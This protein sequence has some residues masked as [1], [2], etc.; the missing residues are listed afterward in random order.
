MSHKIIFMG[1]PQFSVPSLE[2]L[3]KSSYKISCVYTQPPKKSN[4]GHKLNSSLIQKSAEDLNLTVRSP[5]SLNTDEELKHFKDLNP[6]IVV[7]VAYGQL[8]PKKFLNV[9]K[10]GFIN[11]HASLLPRWRGAAPIQR[12]IINLDKETGVS[13]MKI[14][15]ELDSGPIMKKIKMKISPSDSSG[16]ILE[17]LS[18]I[19]SNNIV[20]ALDDIFEGREK[21]IEQDHNFV[22]YAKK[23]KKHEGKIDWKE[24]A[25]FIIGKINGLNP[26]PGAWFEYKKIRYKIWQASIIEKK[27]SVGTILDKSFT[28]A[29]NDQSIRIIEIQKEGKKKL[30]LKDFLLGMNFEVGD[31]IK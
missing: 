4:R 2:I 11:I 9:P 3:S 15:E 13:I 10:K 14:R 17:E 12:A 16:K 18:R 25:K 26:S 31:I 21:F 8:I 1:T 6:D 24:R 5:N 29:C 7:V 27:G 22:T 23:I 19:G 30:L 28:I 20:Q